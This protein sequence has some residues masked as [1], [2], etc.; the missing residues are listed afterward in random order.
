[1]ARPR[2]SGLGVIYLEGDLGAGKTTL[3]RGFLR[4][5]GVEGTIRSPTYTLVEV[6]ETSAVS[7]VHLDL[8][9]LRDAAELEHLGVRELARPG[10]VWLIEWPDRGEGLLPPPDLVV[11]LRGGIDR[12]EV[13]V[14]ATSALGKAWLS[15][16]ENR[17]SHP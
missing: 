7:L 10:Y 17:A 11:S 4:A 12:H 13:N 14:T 2:E 9:R 3:S 15:A 16:V 5:L 6:Y 1:M 8:Y